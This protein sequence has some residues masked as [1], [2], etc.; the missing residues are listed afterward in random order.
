VAK[1]KDCLGRE[2]SLRITTRLLR[3]LREAGFDVGACAKGAEGYLP[4]ADPETLGRVLWVFT[5]ADAKGRDIGEDEF[6]G[7]FDGPTIFAATTALMESVA[8]FTQSPAVAAATKKRLPGAIA[9]REAE[10][11][12]R[13]ET[14]PIGSTGSA[15]RPGD[16]P[17]STPAS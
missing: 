14:A 11:V 13:I 7:G 16:S 5:E 2:W 3:P 15:G 1:F 8:D 10:I 12:R 17:A 6:A 4:L 9:E